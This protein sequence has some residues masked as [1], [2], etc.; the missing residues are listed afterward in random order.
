MDLHLFGEIIGKLEHFGPDATVRQAILADITRLVDGD[1]GASYLWDSKKKRFSD[2]SS[3]NMDPS[4]LARYEERYQFADPI[5]LKLRAK[6]AATG[7]SE[8]IPDSEFYRSE[9]YNDFLRKDGLHRGVNIF[10]F[11]GDHDLGDFRIWRGKGKPDFGEREFTLLNAL[12][13]FLRRAI[14]RTTMAF[15]VLT[16]REREIAALISRGCTDREIAGIL[17]ISFSTVRTHL[18]RVLAKLGCSNRAE[19]AALIAAST[20]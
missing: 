6:R 2:S 19:I 9:F 5:T 14:V 17:K 1:F 7:V 18:N 11:D 15:E 3:V 16:T 10:L 8:I 4:N 13:P 20:H 12:E